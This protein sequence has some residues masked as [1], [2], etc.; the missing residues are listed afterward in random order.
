MANG[1][2]RERG[3]QVIIAYKLIKGS[4]G[5]AVALLLLLL[6]TFD[7]ADALQEA[8]LVLHAHVA[9]AWSIRLADMLV[10]ATSP[11]YVH[12]AM[13]ALALDGS[14]TLIEGWALRRRFAWAPW[15]VVIA[16]TALL[17]LEIVAIVNHRRIGRVLVLVANVA[18]VVYLVRHALW[19]ARR[20]ATTRE[21]R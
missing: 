15:L 7:G 21:E 20:I 2:T 18:I 17:P 14:L 5:V 12:L 10:R 4:A 3:L 9:G 11:H 8:A 13:V 19:H 6:T 1:T 16:T